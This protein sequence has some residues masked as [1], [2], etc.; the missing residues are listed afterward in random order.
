MLNN[1]LLLGGLLG[2]LLGLAICYYRTIKT[3]Y[4]N[5]AKIQTVSDVTNVL[6]DFGIKL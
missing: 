1:S 5:R 2:L 3:A 4:E 6:N